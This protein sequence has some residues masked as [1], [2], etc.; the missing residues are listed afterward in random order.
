MPTDPDMW[1][2]GK[3][4]TPENEYFATAKRWD[5]VEE[6]YFKLSPKQQYTSTK[7]FYKEPFTNVSMDQS[8]ESFFD[9][10]TG[11]LKCARKLADPVLISFYEQLTW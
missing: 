6:E 3:L 9:L 11:K 10:E 4:E 5:L 2:K 7:Y 1:R 8:I